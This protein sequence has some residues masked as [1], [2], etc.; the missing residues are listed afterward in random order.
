MSNTTMQEEIKINK[1][2]STQLKHTVDD[3]LRKYLTSDANYV[4]NHQHMDV[5]LSLGYL[6]CLFAA[7]ATYYEW[8]NGFQKAKPVTLICVASYFVINFIAW[9]YAYFIEKQDVFV[10]TKD[11]ATLKISAR[12]ARLSETYTLDF[13]FT[14]GKKKGNYTLES[15]FGKWFNE[16]GVLVTSVLEADV[17]SAIE[18]S[19]ISKEQ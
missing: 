3:H 11:G 1:Y 19:T 18:R 12:L 6:S 7:A 16:D 13:H 15:S 9:V 17:K 8:K 2:D 4:E 14:D 5:K 10:G